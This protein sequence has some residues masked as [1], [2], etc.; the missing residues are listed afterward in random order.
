MCSFIAVMFTL[1]P[2]TEEVVEVANEA[3]MFLMDED[4]NPESF[5]EEGSGWEGGSLPRTA[6]STELATD[7][8]AS[9]ENLTEPAAL[10][11]SPHHVDEY[12]WME[13]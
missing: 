1:R 9:A 10:V 2:I 8:C 5:G 11:F 6:N 13:G 3:G 7:M 12:I 4:I